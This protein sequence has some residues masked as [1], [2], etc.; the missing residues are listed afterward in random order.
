MRLAQYV[1]QAT[2]GTAFPALSPLISALYYGPYLVTIVYTTALNAIA[3][4]VV[5]V[6]SSVRSFPTA[7]SPISV[8]SPTDSDACL[9]SRVYPACCSYWG[10]I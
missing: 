6:R 7:F 1:L 3:N 5:S 8:G 4:A 10:N 9:T 2:L